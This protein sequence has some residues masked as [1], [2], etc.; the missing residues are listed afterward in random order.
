MKFPVYYYLIAAAVVV[1]TVY[2]VVNIDV[3]AYLPV[4]L[5]RRLL[6]LRWFLG[7]LGG[8]LVI[9]TSYYKWSHPQS[10]K[11]ELFIFCGKHCRTPWSAAQRASTGNS[12]RYRGVDQNNAERSECKF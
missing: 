10:S 1:A 11:S 7:V 4:G 9:A 6:S 3:S 8:L 2:I 5:S 12:C